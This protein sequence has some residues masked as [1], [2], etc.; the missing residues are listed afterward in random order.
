M[1]E[2]GATGSIQLNS[3]SKFLF[4]YLFWINKGPDGL[5]DKINEKS[6]DFSGHWFRPWMSVYFHVF[7]KYETC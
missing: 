7:N 2:C 1:D 5:S 3:A 4:I 6:L